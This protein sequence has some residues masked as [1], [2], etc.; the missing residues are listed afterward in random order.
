MRPLTFA[1]IAALSV[2]APAAALALQVCAWAPGPAEGKSDI[3]LSGGLVLSGVAL[4]PGVG[5]GGRVLAL[6]ADKKFPAAGIFILDKAFL[7]RLESAHKSA[8]P[9][10]WRI[11]STAPALKVEYARALESNFRIADVGI[12]FDGELLAVFGVNRRR[13]G[14][15]DAY[16]AEPP[17]SLEIRDKNLLEQAGRLAID[18]GKKVFY[19]RR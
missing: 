12:S 8:A 18:A 14:G 10:A 19:A 1:A 4:R 2:F 3:A 6:A 16:A 11:L 7:E 5:P 17:A 9:R 15:V 13:S